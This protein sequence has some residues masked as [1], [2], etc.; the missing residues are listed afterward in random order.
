MISLG[1][2]QACGHGGFFYVFLQTA[3]TRHNRLNIWHNSVPFYVVEFDASVT[4][5][6]PRGCRKI[7]I[8]HPPSLQYRIKIR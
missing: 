1:L 2:K 5:G 3:A 7:A 8:V 6:L 4:G